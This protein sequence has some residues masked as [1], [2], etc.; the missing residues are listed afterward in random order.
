MPTFRPAEETAQSAG[1]WL[2]HLPA[3]R[4]LKVIENAAATLLAM[5]AIAGRDLSAAFPLG[6]AT[7]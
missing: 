2:R 1:P 6:R 7:A 4:Y 3:K 5:L